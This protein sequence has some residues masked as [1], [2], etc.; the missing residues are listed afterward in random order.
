MWDALG[1]VAFFSLQIVAYNL[2]NVKIFYAS[3]Q[4]LKSEMHMDL[5]TN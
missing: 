5:L 4:G 3:P 1:F 2:E